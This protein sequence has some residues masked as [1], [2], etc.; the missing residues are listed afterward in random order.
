M[1]QAVHH[2]SRESIWTL[3]R[4][5]D[6]PNEPLLPIVTLPRS[7]KV[8]DSEYPSAARFPGMLRFIG[9]KTKIKY[10]HRIGRKAHGLGLKSA[11]D[12][13]VD[14]SSDIWPFEGWRGFCMG[15]A[16]ILE[17]VSLHEE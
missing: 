12:G 9:I 1:G 8:R 10:F 13:V 7:C 6:L 5:S 15:V 17:S 4:Q 14:G 11:T 16:F 3:A 2:V